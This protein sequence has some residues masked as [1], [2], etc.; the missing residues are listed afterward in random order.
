M[1]VIL[2]R[3]IMLKPLCGRVFPFILAVVFVNTAFAQTPQITTFTPARFTLNNAATVAVTVT[4]DQAMD[5]ATFNSSN[6]LIYGERTGFHTGTYSYDAGTMTASFAGTTPFEAGE[7]VTIILTDSILNSTGTGL[8][9]SFQWSFFIVTTA[10]LAKFD[11]D[12]TY[13]TGDGPHFVGLAELTGDTSQDIAIPHSKDGTFRM[14]PNQGDGT[15]GSSLSSSVGNSPRS[16][17]IADLDGDNDM[18]VAVGNQNDNTVSIAKNDGSGGFTVQSTTIAVGLA[19]VFVAAGDLDGD[20]DIDLVVVNTSDNNISILFNS[21]NANFPNRTDVAV[22]TGPQA[23]FVDDFNNDGFMDIAVTNSSSSTVTLLLNNG[24]GNF[25]VSDQAATD[26]GPRTILGHDYNLDGFID[27][28]T[29]NRNGNSASILISRGDGTFQASVNVPVGTDPFG[30]GVGD[31]DGD[32]DPDLVVSNRLSNNVSVLIN[33]GTGTFVTDSTYATGLE[34]RSLNVADMNGDGILDIVAAAWGDDQVHL[35]FNRATPVIN[36][37]PAAPVANL[38]ADKAF[39]NQTA[40]PIVLN[41]NVPVDNDADSLHF[42]VEISQT[43]NFATTVVTADSRVDV[44]GFTPTPKVAQS[45]TDVSYAVSAILADG[46]YYWRVTAHDGLAFGPSSTARKFTVDGTNPNIDSAT[47][48]NP[49]PIFAPDWYNPLTVSTVDLVVQYDE[50]NAQNVTFDLGALGGTQQNSITSGLN[51]TTQVQITITG[52]ADGGYPLAATILDSAGNSAA[53][54]SNI[55]L[56]GSAPTGTNATSPAVSQTLSFTVDW[57]GSG[58]DGAGSGLSGAFDV[59]F[60]VDGGVWSPWLTNFQGTSSAF[61]GE[62]G[63]TYGFEAGAHDNVGNVELLLDLAETV[64]AVDT[65]TD[66]VAPGAPLNLTANSSNPSPWQGNPLFSVSWQNPSDVSGIAR[67]FY[68]IGAAPTSNADTSGSVAG[69]TTIIVQATEEN[70]QDF[71]LWLSDGVGNSDFNNNAVVQLRY[72]ATAPTGAVASSPPVSGNQMFLVSWGGTGSDG[73]GSGLSGIYD[74]KVQVNSGSFSDWLTNFTGTSA[75]YPGEQGNTYG[76]EVAAHDVAGNVEAFMLTAESETR[77]D[78]TV[79]DVTPPGPALSLLANGANPSAWQNSASFLVSWQEP[80]DQSGIAAALYKLGNAPVSNFDTTGSVRTGSSIQ[81][82]VSQPDGQDF[83]VWFQD[84]RGNVDFQNTARVRLRY[85]DAPPEIFEMDLQ[86]IGFLPNWY[87][88]INSPTVQVILDYTERHASQVTLTSTTLDTT[89]NVLNVVSGKDVPVAFNLNV[90]NKADGLYGL[91][92]TVGDSAGTADADSIEFRLDATPPTGTT[93][94][95]PDTSQTPSFTVSWEG[96][97]SDGNGSGLSGVYDIRFREGG[98]AWQDWLTN[99]V[100]TSSDFPG[101]E[102]STY[103]FEAAAYDN[104]GNVEAFLQTAESSTVVAEDN[105]FVTIQH[106]QPFVIDEGQDATFEIDVQSTNPVTEAKLFY[107]R[108]NVLDFTEVVMMNSAGT[109]YQITV[110]A[111]EFGTIGINYFFRVGDGNGFTFLPTTWQTLPFHLAI[112]IMGGADNSGLVAPQSQ[113]AGMTASAFRM[114][115][116]PLNLNDG[117]PKGVLEDD[118]GKYDATKWRLFQFDSA[119]NQ[120]NEF[121]NVSNFDPKRALWLIIRA[122]NLTIDSGIGTTVPT[123]QPFEVTLNQGW[124][125]IGMPFTFPVSSSNVQVVSGDASTVVGPYTYG[126]QGWIVP[127]NVNNLLPWEGYSF[128][129]EQAG[130]RIAI[131]PNST[132]GTL[133]KTLSL[134]SGVAPEWVIRIHAS[135]AVLSDQSGALGVASDAS[136]ERDLHDYLEPPFISD[137]VSVRFPHD[138][139]QRLPG[140]YKTDF[141]PSFSDGA[142]WSF[143]V[144]TSMKDRPIT[145]KFEEL[146][147]LPSHLEAI[148]LDKSSL[149]KIDLRRSTEVHFTPK[150]GHLEHE[151]DLVIGT[152]AYVQTSETLSRLVPEVPSLL[153]NYPNPFNAGTTVT[154]HVAEEGPVSV[155]V[156]NILGQRV[157]TLVQERQE[158]GVYEVKWNGTDD[159]NR[160][161]GTGVYFVRLRAGKFHQTRK[162]LLVK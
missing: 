36:D 149:R 1:E 11:L 41:W 5:A 27:V 17:A 103:D 63:K 13:G 12:S 107:R 24:T 98:G 92:F 3:L 59:Q 126:S 25:S 161:V 73:A 20:G 146:Q 118:L 40:T 6:F 18:D 75:N 30:L 130:A 97:G 19:P 32:L 115:S 7:R 49:V 93:T 128:F 85:D 48:T 101:E 83:H 68:K 84:Q 76:F 64:T 51:Q 87:Q 79:N 72:D 33:D 105:S 106:T 60:Q 162:I 34:P 38:P 144:A 148:L 132:P 42:L 80:S 43:A 28:A 141:K 138:D 21:G 9:N 53:V 37:P 104:L 10:G 90:A 125:D 117:D 100:G 31:L 67:A 123:N 102:G 129:S 39:I 154:Y 152:N 150:Q 70:G 16:L 139:W 114:F 137:F 142:V 61:V 86:N 155:T 131:S 4:F 35:F 143:E 151:F 45:V 14:F 99:F 71:H 135:N 109:T 58:S 62:Q 81:L 57:G 158:V 44:T 69:S 119:T 120:Y 26:N 95:S 122:P 157:A 113:P 66:H 54:N 136:E 46:V 121:P 140:R 108:G 116:V 82:S 50:E 29:V 78:T 153:P 52:A 77:V 47:L 55:S 89:I 159:L 22:Q 156:S 127:D 23:A 2:K 111:S 88:Q 56:D 65:V 147:S 124:N 8:A 91:K 94:T 145:L 110:P 160:G 133:S 96:T 134:T 15:L 112:Q 74:I